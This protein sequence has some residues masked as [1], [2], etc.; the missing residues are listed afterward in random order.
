MH[1]QQQRRQR[2]PTYLERTDGRLDGF[3]APPN[4]TGLP[5][6]V[7]VMN[8]SRL[9]R[10]WSSIHGSRRPQGQATAAP[11]SVRVA[12]LTA[13]AMRG[14]R[15]SECWAETLDARPSIRSSP[16]SHRPD[17][18]HRHLHTGRSISGSDR[19]WPAAAAYFQGGED[20]RG[21]SRRRRRLPVRVRGYSTRQRRP[22][23]HNHRAA[24]DTRHHRSRRMGFID[25]LRDWQER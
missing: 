3:G 14:V 23:T 4:D 24:S 7:W 1:C 21:S 20:S 10:P 22:G 8:P 9:S 6:Y 2:P 11:A 25:T 16:R 13:S 15:E 17:F 19:G 5:V 18:A 12:S